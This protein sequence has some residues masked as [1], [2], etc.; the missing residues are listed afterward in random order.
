[1]SPDTRGATPVNHH[2]DDSLFPSTPG[3]VIVYLGKETL[4]SWLTD[5]RSQTH[6]EAVDRFYYL[7]WG[8]AYYTTSVYQLAEVATKV[9][10]DGSAQDASL[11]GERINDSA[12]RV[13]HGG[14]DWDETSQSRTPKDVFMASVELITDRQ[15]L[16]VNFP[17][18]ALIL[19]AARDSR[20]RTEDVYLFTFDGELAILADTF[21]IDVLPYST[22]CRN[23][24]NR[25]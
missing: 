22:P 20:N 9:R 18:A 16:T 3:N 19:D 17:E 11:L 15:R 21:G 25:R 6:E 13:V 5:V 23:D 24:S 7:S 12:I 2:S 8:Q 10:Y 14:D 4:L 1:V